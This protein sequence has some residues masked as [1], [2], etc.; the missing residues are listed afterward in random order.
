MCAAPPAHPV[1][2]EKQNSGFFVLPCAGQVLALSNPAFVILLSLSFLLAWKYVEARRYLLMIGGAF[3]L[4]AVAATLQVLWPP[5]DATW[6]T[7]PSVVLDVSCTLLLLRGILAYAGARFDAVP[8]MILAA[9]QLAA[10]AY[11]HYAEPDLDARIYILNGGAALIFLVGVARLG[12]LRTGRPVDR[13]L[14]WIFLLFALSF[15]PRMVLKTY[16]TLDAHCTFSH[17]PYWIAFQLVLPLFFAMLALTLLAATAMDVFDALRKERDTDALTRLH[18]RRSFERLARREIPPRHDRPLSLVLCDIDYFKYINDNYGHTAGDIVL[19][20][21][22]GIIG[23]NVRHRDIAARIGGEE[24]VVMLPDTGVVSARALA[25]RLRQVLEASRFAALPGAHRV[26]ASFGVAELA[27]G[28][29][30]DALL[31]RADS[32]LYAAKRK[33]RNCVECDRQVSACMQAACAG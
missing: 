30:L 22:G 15:L 29:S 32:L 17:S 10:L 23:E 2:Q 26:T 21:F 27:P 19:S 31:S 24:F 9:L 3:F 5:E 16:A 20:T 6:N 12:R 1:N 7:M 11:F 14:Y 13:A 8:L 28:E 18:N 33:G 25:D 4:Y